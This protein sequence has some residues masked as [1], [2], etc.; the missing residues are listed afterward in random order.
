[1]LFPH[2]PLS[3]YYCQMRRA[4]SFL[5]FLIPVYECPSSISSCNNLV[6]F[7]DPI[8][9]P[10]SEW[11]ELKLCVGLPLLAAILNSSSQVYRLLESATLKTLRSMITYLAQFSISSDHDTHSRSAAASCLF[12]VVFHSNGDD[13]HVIQNLL[14]KVVSPA[15]TIALDCLLKEV[16]DAATPRASGCLIETSKQSMQSTFSRVEDALSFLGLLVSHL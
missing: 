15:L 11:D 6:E 14:E 2:R 7:V 16:T 1:M 12:S 3:F 10:L 4:Y 9:P 13:A 5:P 8:M